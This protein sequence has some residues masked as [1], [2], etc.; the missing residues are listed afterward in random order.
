M[1]K[2]RRWL[3][4]TSIHF[5][6]FCLYNKKNI[7]RW[8]EDMNFILFLLHEHKIHI[9][10]PPCNI[11]C[12]SMIIYHCL[13]GGKYHFI[14]LLWQKPKR[15]EWGTG[16]EACQT[17]LDLERHVNQA[18]LDLHKVADTHNDPQVNTL[19][20]AKSWL[21]RVS[22]DHRQKIGS[23]SCMLSANTNSVFTLKY[24]LSEISA[25]LSAG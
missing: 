16:L 24:P 18:L 5:C 8:L 12:L 1:Q 21:I 22:T 19:W 25:A 13:R 4:M 3:H 15:D 17:A 14:Y 10:S 9:C 23:S 6:S 11:L 2:R 7:T 20:T